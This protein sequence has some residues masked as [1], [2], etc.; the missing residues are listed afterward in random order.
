MSCIS[1]NTRYGIPYSGS[2]SRIAERIIDV[3]PPGPVFI[4]AFAGGCAVTHAALASGKWA[5]VIAND[6]GTGPA[7]FYYACRYGARSWRWVSREEFFSRKDLDPETR[8]VWSFG[9]AGKAYIYSREIEPFKRAGHLSIVDGDFSGYDNDMLRSIVEQALCNV[10]G[11]H[12]RYLA[13][14]RAI[15]G[16]SRLGGRDELLQ[17]LSGLER[18]QGLQGLER[19]ERL[20]VTRHDYRDLRFPQDAVIYCDPPYRNTT[21]C[22]GTPFNYGVFYQ[23]ARAVGRCHRVYISEYWMPPDFEC[24]AEFTVRALAGVGVAQIQKRVE[25]LYTLKK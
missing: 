21:N 20:T 23:W 7:L 1:T 10:S 14:Q 11:I 22:Y 16:L 5:S 17:G 25:K 15:R 9:N 6:L 2:K 18:L 12:D 24:V 4:D 13:Y 3:L 19:L 8:L